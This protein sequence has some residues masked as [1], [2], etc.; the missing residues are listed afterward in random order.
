M[1]TYNSVTFFSLISGGNLIS[2]S[3]ETPV[4]MPETSHKAFQDL[5]TSVSAKMDELEKKLKVFETKYK[6]EMEMIILGQL[7]TVSFF[8]FFVFLNIKM[9]E[10]MSE[11]FDF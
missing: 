2:S 6:S 11:P 9:S 1:C 7:R 5:R 10:V 3:K 8:L 4:Y